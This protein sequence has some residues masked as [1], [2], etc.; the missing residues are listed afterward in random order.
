MPKFIDLTGQKFGRWTVLQRV[1]NHG[2]AVYWL[3]ECS[4]GTR[5]EVKGAH[6]RSGAS[7]SCGCRQKE[8]AKEWMKNNIGKRADLTGQK[9]GHLT[10]LKNVGINKYHV[11]LWECECDCENHTHLIVP[12]NN[13][14]TGNTSSCG[15]VGNSKGQNKIKELLVN[16]NIDFET[17][18][19]FASCIYPETRGYLRYD[20]FLP[21]YNTCIEYDGEQHYR[22]K[23]G[24]TP[25]LEIQA[26]DQYKNDWC[27]K[28]NVTLIRIPYTHFNNIQIQ[29]LLP[30]TSM[31]KI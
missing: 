30:D 29:D 8:V 2:N 21:N 4:C 27:K 17:E 6:L 31:F 20:F 5:K 19:S 25:L 28:N 13:L 23:P 16:N 9:F 1:P 11:S 7:T 24:W 26:R 14:T 18:K 22:Q 15:C 12:L 3:C 10:A